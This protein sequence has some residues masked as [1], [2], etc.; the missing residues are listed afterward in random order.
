QNTLPTPSKSRR[1]L[2]HPF[3]PPSTPRTPSDGDTVFYNRQKNSG[4]FHSKFW[5]SSSERPCRSDPLSRD[6]LFSLPPLTQ[7]NMTAAVS[8]TV[9]AVARLRPLPIL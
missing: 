7:K 2:P 5:I 3:P 9:P 6:L 1:G 8:R 4:C